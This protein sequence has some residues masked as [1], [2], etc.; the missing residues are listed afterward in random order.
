MSKCVKRKT[1]RNRKERDIYICIYITLVVCF[2]TISPS[3]INMFF[4]CLSLFVMLLFS[5]LAHILSF[6]AQFKNTSVERKSETCQLT[7]SCVYI[8]ALLF[9]ND[10][11]M[12]NETL[13]N[14]DVYKSPSVLCS[15]TFKKH[16]VRWYCLFVQSQCVLVFNERIESACMQVSNA[17]QP[18]PWI[19]IIWQLFHNILSFIKCFFH[20]S[21][22]GQR[23]LR[24]YDQ[25]GSCTVHKLRFTSIWK[26]PN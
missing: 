15:Q 6:Y 17:A 2:R 4:S 1:K 11:L 10:S 13:L 3:V 14:R 12:L 20:K 22:S 26:W 7:W 21:C 19:N 5:V 9:L 23:N 24:M 18:H 8:D 16:L 25:V